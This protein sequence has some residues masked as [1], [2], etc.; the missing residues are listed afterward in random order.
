MLEPSSPGVQSFLDKPKIVDKCG[1]EGNCDCTFKP[2]GVSPD[3]ESM[4]EWYEISEVYFYIYC[5]FAPLSDGL[6]CKIAIEC[7]FVV[8]LENSPSLQ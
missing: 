5:F 2:V 4:E 3:G 8:G 1:Q 7:S 6:K